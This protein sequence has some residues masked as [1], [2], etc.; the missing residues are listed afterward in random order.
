MLI[1]EKALAL[2][3]TVEQMGYHF[4]EDFAL[5]QAKEKLLQEIQICLQNI[6]R[7]EEKYQMDYAGFCQ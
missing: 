4:I 1:N 7:F 5:Q 3:E 2:H 6:A